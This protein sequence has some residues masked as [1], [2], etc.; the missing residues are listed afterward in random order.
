[1]QHLAIKV[2]YSPDKNHMIFT[3]FAITDQIYI[4][5][6]VYVKHSWEKIKKMSG[7]NNSGNNKPLLELYVKVIFN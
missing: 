4:S 7:G 1:M 6:Y 5:T 2:K 3:I